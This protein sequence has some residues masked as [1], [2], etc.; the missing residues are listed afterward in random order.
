MI[1]LRRQEQL[2]HEITTKFVAISCKQNVECPRQWAKLPKKKSVGV[3][4]LE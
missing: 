4:F 3:Y 1:L 2:F